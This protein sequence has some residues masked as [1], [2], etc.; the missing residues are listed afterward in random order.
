VRSLV[1][2]P[3][4][5]ALALG[6]VNVVPA[7]GAWRLEADVQRQMTYC[8]TVE[9]PMT[10]YFCNPDAIRLNVEEGGNTW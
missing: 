1:K 4:A 9:D 7:I 8:R 6:V 10:P 2:L 5:L 3:I